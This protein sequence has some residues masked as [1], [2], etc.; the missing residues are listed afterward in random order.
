MTTMRAALFS[1]H[2]GPEVVHM[3]EMETPEPGPGQVRI[4]VRAASLNHLDLWT[5]RGLPFEI[6][7]GK[8]V[9][10]P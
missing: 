9:L 7:I 4:A 2:G 3:S 8:L 6:P 10:V 1:E 5:R